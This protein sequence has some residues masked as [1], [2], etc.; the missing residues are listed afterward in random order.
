MF[1]PKDIVSG[2]FYWG[3]E[4]KDYWYVAVADCTGHGVPG[5]F[6]TMLGISFLNEIISK[7]EIYTPANMLDI[8][9]DKIMNELGHAGKS[10]MTKDGM[11]I[12]LLRINL[13]S[14][15]VLWAG[16]NN[17]L[18]I[19]RKE[20]E[21]IEEIKPDKQPVGFV[22]DPKPFTNHYTHIVKDDS[23]FIFSDGYPDQFG[24]EK[25]KKFKYS[26][27]KDMLVSIR[28]LSLSGQKE[29]LQNH[30]D[31][32]KGDQEQVDDV[33]VIGIRI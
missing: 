29:Y 27:F 19:L 33:C 16:A 32:W 10:G 6:M 12:S 31:S 9:R 22:D 26:N 18:W 1:R 2:D 13:K 5:A 3:V 24:G 4:K 20:S 17:P 15:E 7:E 23:L 21:Q 8:L 30:F 28:A 25:G 14:G 11:D